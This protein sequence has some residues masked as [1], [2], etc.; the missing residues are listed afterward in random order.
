MKQMVANVSSIYQ[1]KKALESGQ[2]QESEIMVQGIAKAFLETIGLAK[3]LYETT[4]YAGG[5]GVQ[6]KNPLEV[7]VRMVFPE[8]K[9]PFSG[10]QTTSLSTSRIENMR[11]MVSNPRE[12]T[13]IIFR[14]FSKDKDSY[15]LF[16]ANSDYMI[17][18][19]NDKLKTYVKEGGIEGKGKIDT[20]F[21]TVSL[22][23]AWRNVMDEADTSRGLNM[24]N[25]F[26]KKH[27]VE[28]TT[29]Y[30]KMYTSAVDEANY[31]KRLYKIKS[32]EAI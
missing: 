13:E 26:L 15:N 5:Y 2:M 9:Y 3:R 7:A 22:V 19:M 10:K 25:R 29:M 17:N 11:Q 30:Q 12:S 23:T 24:V 31:H 28:D 8:K 1:Q 27:G 21:K 4:E 14:A 6:T 32:G 20:M 16:K 18:H